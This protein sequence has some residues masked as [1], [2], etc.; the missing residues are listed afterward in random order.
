MVLKEKVRIFTVKVPLEDGKLYTEGTYTSEWRSWRIKSNTNCW[1]GDGNEGT[2]T[3][4]FAYT[5]G[6]NHNIIVV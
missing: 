2:V 3:I 6:G 4:A 5:P 1:L